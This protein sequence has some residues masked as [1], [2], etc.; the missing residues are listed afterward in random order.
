MVIRGI[1]GRCGV[2]P[3]KY[4]P[5]NYNCSF[6]IKCI[7][8]RICFVIHYVKIS[9]FNNFSNLPSPYKNYAYT[10]DDSNF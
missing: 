3:I 5:I 9:R 8:N 7:E 6:K 1:K 4:I 2:R 10:I